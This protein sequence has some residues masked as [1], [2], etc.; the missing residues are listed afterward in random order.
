[1]AIPVIKGGSAELPSQTL[2]DRFAT[3][4]QVPPQQEAPAPQST[5]ILQDIADTTPEQIAAITQVDASEL[6]PDLII[7]EQQGN[8]NRFLVP[9]MATRAQ[10]DNQR[11]NRITPVQPPKVTVAAQSEAGGNIRSRAKTLVQNVNSGNLGLNLTGLG[12][13]AYELT[14]GD[15]PVSGPALSDAI[16][17][18]SEGNIVAAISRSDAIVESEGGMKIPN[19]MYTQI[20][21]A[22]IEDTFGGNLDNTLDPLAEAMGDPSVP[23][24]SPNKTLTHAEG[25]AQ[26]GNRIHLEYQR[27][28]RQAMISQGAPEADPQV[29]ALASPD[30]LPRKEAETLGAAFKQLWADSN[31][32]LVTRAVDPKTRQIVYGLTAEGEAAIKEGELD[33][34]KIFPRQ[35][36]RPQKVPNQM[37]GTD[38]GK[39]VV[40]AVSGGKSGQRMGRIINQAIDNLGQVGHVVDKQRMKIL[41]STVLATL[42]T[43]N[44]KTW[45]AEI[46]NV[47]QSRMDKFNAAAK[48]QERKLANNPE[49]REEL[50]SPEE[51]INNLFDKLA[52]E[53]QSLA[54]ERNGI[55][56][57]TYNVQGFQGRLTPQQSYFNPVTSKAVRFATRSPNP[58]IIRPG[59]RQEKNLRQMYA[60]ILLS[61]VK[62]SQGN[63]ITDAG[64]TFLPA[65]REV[66]LKARESELYGYGKRLAQALEMTDAQYEAVSEAIANGVPLDSPQFPQFNQ[67]SLDPNSDYDSMIIKMIKD[68]GED[69]LL[70]MDTLIDFSKYVDFKRNYPNDKQF[71]SY[72]NAY[73][74]GKTNGPASQGMQMGEISTAFL[75]GVLRARGNRSTLLD[76]GDIRDKLMGL[77]NQSIESGWE[78]ISE[79]LFPQ[80]NDVARA[81]FSNRDLAKLTIMTYGYGKEMESFVTD[82]EEVLEVL[83]EKLI[84]D[85]ESSYGPS[86]SI[87]DSTMSRRDL[88]KVLLEKYK[89]AIEGVMTADSIESRSI[90]RAVAALHAAMN[91]PFIIK[92]P[93]GMDI[94]IGGE[95]STGYDAAS[96]STYKSRSPETGDMVKTTV[97]HYET[98]TTAAATRNRTNPDGTIE[99]TPGEFAYGGSVV[100]PIQAVD[101]ATVAMTA[102]GKSWDRAGKASNGN[103]FLLTIYDAFKV[104]AN[105]YD[106]FLEEIN[107]NWM[108]ATLDW[109]YLEQARNSLTE[110]T[111]RFEEKMK[112][113]KPD[114][115]LTDN[116]KV[117]MD[118]MLKVSPAA[119][120]N[121]YMANL[122]GRMSK[123]TGTAGKVRTEEQLREDSIRMS[124]VMVAEMKKVGYDPYNPPSE[125]TVNQLKTFKGLLRNELNLHSRLPDLIERTNSNKVALRKELLMNGYKTE[126]GRRIPFQYYAH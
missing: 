7:P 4:E 83:N 72:V 28:K 126:S 55:N 66:M 54:Q 97:A 115:K 27:R 89:G 29:Q 14:K 117:Y 76:D 100:A 52:Q 121:M 30:K 2:E 11:Y 106:V 46:N 90:M 113:R 40:R 69:G 73:M 41:Y 33:R 37:A 18:S 19:P 3:T 6:T 43:S 58:S 8:D 39:N 60:M 47:G 82:I 118:W 80:L 104:D 81:V 5:G 95:S 114:D 21:S 17:E 63:T 124:R 122:W 96:K 45:Q 48:M 119:S 84:Q 50:Y 16:A 56:Y 91:E 22:I 62:D 74:D 53:V 64:D 120:G 101:A 10:T 32:T 87:I 112:G 34:K 110:A 20:A 23:V 105:G 123:L 44:H 102:S 108:D 31:P 79:D 26:I 70:L 78:N 42:A 92:G 86:L 65:Q 99:G 109:S 12:T 35:I 125:P 94:H 25:N 36:V 111:K 98:E 59:N 13:P 67:L 38:V 9:D 57:L 68:K 49:L 24:E 85:S 75:T 71:I 1:M 93:T 51:N 103:P 107:L 15:S 116:E 61:K 77:A 88:A